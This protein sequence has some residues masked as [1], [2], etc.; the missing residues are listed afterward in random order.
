M[1]DAW[2][3][4]VVDAAIEVHR[5]LGPAFAESVYENALCRELELRDVPFERQVTVPLE[6]KGIPIGEGRVDVQVG[7]VLVV[8]LKALPAVLPVHG[9]QVISYLKATG[10]SLGLLLNFGERTLKTGIRRVALTR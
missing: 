1:V 10:L 8:E 6:Y 5:H 3:A 9:S 4:V 7:G 2:A